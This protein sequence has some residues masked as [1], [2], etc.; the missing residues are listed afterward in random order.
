MLI[1]LC[2]DVSH[3]ASL[4]VAVTALT[5]HNRVVMQLLQQAQQPW[6]HLASR[7]AGLTKRRVV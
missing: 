1:A 7:A 2:R 6:L 4:L 5:S 3:L